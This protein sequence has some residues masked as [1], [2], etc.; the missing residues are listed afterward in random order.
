MVTEDFPDRSD[1]KEFDGDWVFDPWV[2]KIPWR[3]K[4][5]PSPVFWP[6]EFHE[7]SMHEW[8]SL[9]TLVA[10]EIDLQRGLGRRLLLLLNK[11]F[12][13]FTIFLGIKTQKAL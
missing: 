4:R 13:P 11:C 3:R 7:Q 2:G 1:G 8:L 10:V 6:R 12:L 5:L 9:S